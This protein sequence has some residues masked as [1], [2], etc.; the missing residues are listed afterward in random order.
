MA[1]AET[2][3]SAQPAIVLGLTLLILGLS[4][5]LPLALVPSSAVR[6]V[7]EHWSAEVANVYALAAWAGWAHFLYAFRG[8]GTALSKLRDELKGRRVLAYSLLVVIALIVLLAARELMGLT[9]FSALVWVY[10]IDHFIKAER[11]F[12]GKTSKF[13]LLS[14]Y[15]PLLAFG[16]L[17]IVLYDVGGINSLRWVLWCVSLG[18][19]CILLLFGGWQ[20][21]SE[22]EVRGPILSLL[23]IAEA[24]VWGTFSP[25]GGPMFLA[26]VYVFHIAAGSYF[27][28]LGSYFFANGAAGRR[29]K[30]V[31]VAPILGINIVVMI[32][33]YLVAREER[34]AVLVPILGIQ[35]F[36]LWV[37]LHLVSSDLFPI[38]KKWRA[39]SG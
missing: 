17:S 4:F 33:G 19:A 5:A 22:G 11:A 37:G 35:W 3:P 34:L 30:L 27:H 7:S 12:D 9:L 8:Q 23:F 39:P 2:R 26:G 18:L 21:L 31:G 25:Y 29:D 14:S 32:A 36:T 1:T 16:W 24:L 10:F 28:Y 20:K 15:Q 6:T 13:R 38:I